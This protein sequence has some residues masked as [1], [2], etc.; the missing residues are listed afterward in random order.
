MSS[1]IRCATEGETDRERDRRAALLVPALGRRSIVLIGLMGSGKTST[2]RRL[3]QQLGLE[4]VD[5]DAEIEA[6]AGVS[7]TE[8]F[9]R[10]GEAYF[11]DGERRVMAR[12]LSEGPRVIA[13]GGGAFMNEETRARIAASGISVWLKADPDVLW[14]RVRKRSHRPLLHGADPEQTLRT[15]LEERYPVYARA[16]ITVISRDG[17]HEIAVEETI[18]GL[19]Y[20]LRFSPEPVPL[21][22]VELKAHRPRGGTGHDAVSQCELVSVDLGK[23]TYAIMIG[24]DLISDAGG[25]IRQLAPRA[26]CAI[27]TDENVAKL[28]L[29]SLERALDL[30]SIRHS[31]VV[32]APGEES[33]SF[34]VFARVCNALISAKLERGDIVIALGGGVIGDLTGFAAATLRRGMRFVQVPT[35]LLA[36]VDSSVGG[37]TGINSPHG[38]NLIGAFHQPSLVLADTDTLSTLPAR[39]FRAGYAEVVKYGLIG[40]VEFFNWLEANWRGVFAGGAERVHA[41]ATSCKAKAAIV[42][43]DETEAGERALLNLGHTF[44][45]A[46]ER[47]TRYDGQRLVHGE[48]IAIG[49]ACAFRFSVRQGLCDKQDQLRVEAHLREVGLPVRISAIPGWSASADDILDAM[50]QD[51]KVEHGALTFILARGIGDCFVAKSVEANEMRAFVEDELVTG[52]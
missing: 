49:M 37:K 19:E 5:A 22:E 16:D 10:H 14:R 7:I 34:E 43:R 30:A 29:P 44:G 48:G 24:A 33:K 20:F 52:H 25:L 9:T 4:F 35:S 39:E 17:P 41:I 40:D 42:A 36:Q 21:T 3:A 51:K 45:H 46:L 18:A 50:Y 26:A 28:Y 15:L 12:L 23:R 38:K 11:R 2:G 31:A 6:A 1:G 8:M 47:V 32:V 13:T 27:V